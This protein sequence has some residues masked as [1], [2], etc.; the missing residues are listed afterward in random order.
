M[1]FSKEKYHEL[2]ELEYKMQLKIF[3]KKHL[4]ASHPMT[5]RVERVVARIIQSNLDIPE[6]KNT[7]WSTVV[8]DEPEI[9]NALVVGDGKIL[10]FTGSYRRIWDKGSAK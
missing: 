8:I 9:V 2:S 3:E 1:A 4:P 6:F 5:K 7:N 10:V